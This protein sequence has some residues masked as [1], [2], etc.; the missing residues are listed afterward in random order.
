MGIYKV[1]IMSE[2]ETIV[3]KGDKFK[4]LDILLRMNGRVNPENGH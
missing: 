1:N 4:M 2:N 3:K